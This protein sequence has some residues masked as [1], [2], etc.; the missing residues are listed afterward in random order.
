MKILQINYTNPKIS[1]YS[2]ITPSILQTEN[3]WSAHPAS[4]H[5]LF[6]HHY[7]VWADVDIAGVAEIRTVT[8]VYFP[9]WEYWNNFD[10]TEQKN[11][12]NTSA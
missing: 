4:T 9:S 3:K 2:V 11:H 7:S 8:K 12:N 10:F 1:D 6:Y 5:L